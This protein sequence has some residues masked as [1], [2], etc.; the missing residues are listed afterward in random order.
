MKIKFY[1]VLFFLTTIPLAFIS[2]SDEDSQ[3]QSI[4]ARDR[5]EQQVSDQDSLQTYLNTHYYNSGEIMSMTA[6]PRIEDIQITKLADGE[7]LPNGSTMLIDAV[8]QRQTIFEETD[9][10]YYTLTLKQGLGD[11]PNFCD[12]VRVK[13]DGFLT[14]NS[15]F[16]E[17]VTSVDVDLA[18]SIAGWNRVLPQFKT[19]NSYTI[20]QDGTVNYSNYGIGVMFLPSGLS[21]YNSAAPGIPAYSSLIFK[22]ELHQYKEMDHDNDY[23]PTYMEDLNGDMDL[24]NDNSDEDQFSNFN[25]IDDDGDGY[26]TYREVYSL[27]LTDITLNALEAQMDLIEPLNSNQFFLPVEQ[28]ES[29]EYSVKL[30][31][32]EDSNGNGIP[33]YLDVTD[34]GTLDN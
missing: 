21:Y 13:Y 9:Y 10:T 5:T 15:T 28:N 33:N 16:D 8:E 19:A 18:F 30:I 22:F 27:E 34:I 29:G 23:I 14:N 25:D 20:N 32:L 3:T 7:T 17:S 12:Q 6:Y 31:T 24:L 4:P 11:S 2:C 1:F 26:S